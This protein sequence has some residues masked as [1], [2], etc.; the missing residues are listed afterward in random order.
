[1]NRLAVVDNVAGKK[2]RCVKMNIT[3]DEKLRGGHGTRDWRTDRDIR[4]GRTP[5]LV[6]PPYDD[7][8]L[9]SDLISASISP[10]AEASGPVADLAAKSASEDV[11]SMAIDVVSLYPVSSSAGMISIAATMD[12]DSVTMGKGDLSIKPLEGI[13]LPYSIPSSRS[14]PFGK[15]PLPGLTS[16]TT[17]PSAIPDNNFIQ[18]SHSF[19]DSMILCALDSPPSSPF[20]RRKP[21]LP[22]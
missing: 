4:D 11:N 22:V 7:L 17:Q 21:P 12:L 13:K 16:S 19:S 3:V 8:I 6:L 20:P 5:P 15:P 9:N 14:S 1:M 18:K 2:I 10:T